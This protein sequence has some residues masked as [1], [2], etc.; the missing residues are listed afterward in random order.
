[1]GLLLSSCSDVVSAEI[2]TALEVRTMESIFQKKDH[3]G[4][5]FKIDN[6][7]WMFKNKY[8]F[9][10]SQIKGKESEN[11]YQELKKSQKDRHT[12]THGNCIEIFWLPCQSKYLDTISVCLCVPVVLWSLQ[13]LVRVFTF[14]SLNLGQK[15]LIGKFKMVA[16]DNL[17]KYIC[18]LT[19]HWSQLIWE[20]H[21]TLRSV[22]CHPYTLLNLHISSSFLT[23]SALSNPHTKLDPC[24]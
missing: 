5:D 14:L 23:H 1:M 22:P 17:T 15:K 18:N 20:A 8:I 16:G 10:E 21:T 13:F 11:S 3:L 7:I 9:P 6:L 12:Q 24:H 19:L 2:P 4:G